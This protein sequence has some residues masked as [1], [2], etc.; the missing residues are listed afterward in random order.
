MD[1]ATDPARRPLFLPDFPRVR[2]GL[3]SRPGSSAPLR[4]PS[5]KHTTLSVVVPAG[6]QHCT[7]VN[8]AAET[9]IESS[10]RRCDR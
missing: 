7:S 9:L 6:P 4:T 10:A 1:P 3:S 8:F 5:R 2:R